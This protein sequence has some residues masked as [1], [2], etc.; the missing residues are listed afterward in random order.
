MLPNARN[1]GKAGTLLIMSP[2]EVLFHSQSTIDLGW[3]LI[4][5]SRMLSILLAVVLFVYALYMCLGA[6]GQVQVSS[7]NNTAT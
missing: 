6:R 1:I 5:Y 3:I 4:A 7:S 2:I